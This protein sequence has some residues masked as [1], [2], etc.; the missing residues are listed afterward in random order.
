MAPSPVPLFDLLKFLPLFV[1]KIDRDLLVRFR[2][3]FMD[4]P[5]GVAP[6]L[7]KLRSRFI[8]NWRNFGDLFRCQTK[9][10]E[11]APSFCRPLAWDSERQRKDA[12]R[13]APPKQRQRFRQRRIRGQIRQQVSTLARRSLRKLILNGR[14]RDGEFVREVVVLFPALF[15]LANSRQRG[16]SNH[17]CRQQRNAPKQRRNAVRPG[18]PAAVGPDRNDASIESKWH[19]SRSLVPS[20]RG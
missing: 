1:G 17:G 8:D 6:Y 19:F 14:V 16:N 4:A 2:H 10:G 15:D 12:E 18:S 13:K 3:D 20:L 11:A 5:T 7:L 9:L